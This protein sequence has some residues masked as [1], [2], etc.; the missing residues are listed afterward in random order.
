MN[1]IS[2][3]LVLCLLAMWGQ[4]SQ[5]AVDSNKC[6]MCHTGAM[7]PKLDTFT[8]TQIKEKLIAIRAGK[9]PAKTMAV[10]AKGLSDN[11]IADLAGHFGKK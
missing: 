8:A 1:K 4:A 7:A 5:A 3:V 9:V 2:Q 11:D 6:A 10:I